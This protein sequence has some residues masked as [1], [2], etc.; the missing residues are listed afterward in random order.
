MGEIRDGLI[1]ERLMLR[2][3]YGA[4]VNVNSTPVALAPEQGNI[5]L[6]GKFIKSVL[7][8]R[9]PRI[10]SQLAKLTELEMARGTLFNL[11]PVFMGIGAI[12]YFVT[13]SGVTCPSQQQLWQRV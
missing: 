5:R 8:L 4:L 6:T 9:L 1:D 7:A 10:R 11:L 13:A 2:P 12:L 3:D